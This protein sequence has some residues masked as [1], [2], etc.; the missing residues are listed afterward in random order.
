MRVRRRGGSRGRVHYQTHPPHLPM[1]SS[2]TS[3]R[4]SLCG[5]D[6]TN[7]WNARICN[8]RGEGEEC[9]KVLERYLLP[10]LLLL[11]ISNEKIINSKQNANLRR[12]KSYL[13]RLYQPTV[14]RRALKFTQR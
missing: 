4:L 12:P 9:Q 11:K 3:G 13:R 10:V 7:Q 5:K 6:A 2:P 14:A 8:G 1:G